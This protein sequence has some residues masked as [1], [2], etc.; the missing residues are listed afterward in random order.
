METR[1]HKSGIGRLLF[2]ASNIIEKMNEIDGEYLATTFNSKT[3]IEEVS[4]PQELPQD[5][6]I[7]TTILVRN[8]VSVAN[9]NTD[10]NGTTMI[11][12]D[13]TEKAYYND[14]RRIE[15]IVEA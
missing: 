4:V 13:L 1:Y 9:K 2:S 10:E 5:S 7:N 8:T 11:D 6:R 14:W 3:R 15:I 12:Q